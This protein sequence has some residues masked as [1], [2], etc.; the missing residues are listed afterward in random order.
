MKT[1]T[2][3]LVSVASIIIGISFSIGCNRGEI[4]GHHGGAGE[5]DAVGGNEYGGGGSGSTAICTADFPCFGRKARCVGTSQIQDVIEVGCSYVCGSAPCNG[6]SC[7]SNGPVKECPTGTT[8][9][10]VPIVSG[11]LTAECDSRGG[12]G[13]I[14]NEGGRGG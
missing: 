14:N 6:S 1:T 11:Q 2:R 13:R 5:S 10:D 8:C 4:E 7:I 3:R 9:R 12:G